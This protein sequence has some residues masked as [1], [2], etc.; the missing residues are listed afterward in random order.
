LA[1]VALVGAIV[2]QSYLTNSSAVDL[3]DQ[4]EAGAAAL[5]P[6]LAV[7]GALVNLQSA[8]VGGGST[9]DA[10]TGVN[11][12]LTSINGGSPTYAVDDQTKQAIA[13]LAGQI[14]SVQ[15][16]KPTGRAAYDAYS[17][18]VTLAVNLMRQK[19]GTSH[20]IHD[21]EVDTYF[22]MDAAVVRLPDAITNAGRAADLVGLTNGHAMADSDELA[23]AVARFNV[24]NSAAQVSAGLNQSVDF[25]SNSSLGSNVADRLDAFM[26]AAAAF[27]PPNLLAPSGTIDNP[28]ALATDAGKVYSTALSLAHYL[29]QQLQN[30]LVDRETSLKG[31]WRFTASAAGVSALIALFML[32]LLAAA[33]PRG[34]HARMSG[35][36]SPSERVDD[37]PMAHLTDAQQLFDQEELVHVGRAVRPR[38]RGRSDAF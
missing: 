30:L 34:S 24:A 21:P 18:L 17:G 15:T 13:Q 26:A 33:R 19:A 23:T 37:L 11:N 8:A 4:E 28:A 27:A 7:V 5:H 20:L 2:R 3:T 35:V 16:K 1:L 10:E 31:D 6:M 38:A 9:V 14:R 36:D 32:W 12:A 29:I 25:T 22:V